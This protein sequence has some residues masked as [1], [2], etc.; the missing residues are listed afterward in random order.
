MNTAVYDTT[1]AL[2]NGFQLF[3]AGHHQEAI[4][5]YR[6]V[7]DHHPDQ[8]EA[9]HFLG[10]ISY[11]RGE[12]DLASRLLEQAIAFHPHPPA[13]YFLNLAIAKDQ[14]GETATAIPLY[15]QAIALD[16]ESALAHSRL[17]HGLQQ[18]GDPRG[19]MACYR[20]AME[21]D[22]RNGEPL[23]FLGTLFDE[24]GETATALDWYHAALDRTIGSV[25]ISTLLGNAF[26]RNGLNTE[27]LCCYRQALGSLHQNEPA[28][29]NRQ[30]SN[31]W[32]RL[33]CKNLRGR[34]L[35]IGSGNDFDKEE[36]LYREYFSNSTS[37]TRLDVDPLL[38]PDLI[39]DVQQL[40]G[41]IA[42]QH[43]DVVFSVWALEHVNDIE[44]ALSEIHRILVPSGFFVFGLP[45]NME[46]HS[47][48]C[49]FHRF[50]KAGIEALLAERFHIAQ[51]RPIGPLTPFYLDQ[52]LRLYGEA[53][54]TAPYSHVGIALKT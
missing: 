51:L 12:L 41:L 8:P 18:N 38:F 39:G 22:P 17:G 19:A 54:Q 23:Y 4:R 40:A 25:K 16:P 47:Y 33:V 11:E 43:Y 2:Q 46:Y 49:D 1:S 45:L 32:L 52:R 36:H 48:P 7:L 29:P 26:N 31:A 53:P 28:S 35:S 20:K 44:A 14:E 3:N 27:S 34:V 21:L 13:N 42:D 30:E 9:T 6:E 15:R 37:Y 24:Q 10:I 50:T 5:V